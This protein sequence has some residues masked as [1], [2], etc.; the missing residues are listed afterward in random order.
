MTNDAL[1]V[2]TVC[3]VTLVRYAH[4]LPLCYFL[5]TKSQYLRR[6]FKYRTLKVLNMSPYAWYHVLTYISLADIHIV[7]TVVTCSVINIST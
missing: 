3:H 4:V 7:Y 6:H 1:L 5:L 2:H